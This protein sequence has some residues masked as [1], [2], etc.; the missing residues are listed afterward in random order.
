MGIG[1]V[2]ALWNSLRLA[3]TSRPSDR[4][5]S[6][7]V[8]QTLE[9]MCLLKDLRRQSRRLDT[10]VREA[11]SAISDYLTGLGDENMSVNEQTKYL[12]DLVQKVQTG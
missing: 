4:N 11:T 12:S 6:G 2:E 5:I 3:D 9:L 7:I 1:G 10:V 8:R